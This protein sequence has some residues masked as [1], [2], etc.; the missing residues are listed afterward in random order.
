MKISPAL[1]QE[2]AKY[3]DSLPWQC[4]FNQLPLISA[5]S[6]C[7]GGGICTP[8][9]PPSS[10]SRQSLAYV[11][12][13]AF[14]SHPLSL[15][16]SHSCCHSLILCPAVSVSVSFPHPLPCFASFYMSP[17]WLADFFPLLNSPF[18]FF[19]TLLT[20]LNFFLDNV[21]LRYCNVAGKV[22]VVCAQ[23]QAAWVKFDKGC[24]L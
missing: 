6:E 16:F 11:S 22:F 10:P 21:L 9:P 24:F 2:N 14:P 13:V 18:S 3:G 20:I 15:N 12:A 7:N 19:C 17:S 23:A 5:F 8:P 1:C 4:L